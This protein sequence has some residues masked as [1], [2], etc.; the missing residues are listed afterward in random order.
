M[1]TFWD[2]DQA[3]PDLYD[4]VERHSDGMISF[5]YRPPVDRKNGDA[6]PD[7]NSA[8]QNPPAGGCESGS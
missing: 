6:Q 8:A 7:Q 5:A 4:D 2:P 1:E 3:S